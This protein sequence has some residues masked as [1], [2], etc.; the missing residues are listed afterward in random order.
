MPLNKPL[1]NQ[2]L[3]QELERRIEAG[4]INLDFASQQID[5]QVNEGSNGSIFGI[6][7]KILLGFGVALLIGLAFYYSQKSTLPV[8]LQTVVKINEAQKPQSN[9][10]CYEP[11]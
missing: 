8:Q 11:N 7:R 2:E 9:E 6:N 10:Q 4:T 1:T 5:N 3:L